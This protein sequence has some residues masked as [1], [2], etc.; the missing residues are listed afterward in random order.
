MEQKKRG[1]KGML[2]WAA[3]PFGGERGHPHY[4]F[5]NTSS[6]LQRQIRR[7]DPERK[8]NFK[9]LIGVEKLWKT[10]SRISPSALSATFHATGLW[11]RKNK[12]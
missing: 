12:Y 5:K 7:Q 4:F 6:N 1:A 10:K 8:K 2:P 3:S 11:G 9:L